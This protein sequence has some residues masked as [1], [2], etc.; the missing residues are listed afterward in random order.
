MNETLNEFEAAADL[1]KT[2]GHHT[3]LLK[4]CVG[5]GRS[6]VR[7]GASDEHIAAA[8]H[9]ASEAALSCRA[10]LDQITAALGNSNR[11]A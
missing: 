10:T 7:A 2:L 1:V 6:L 8:R 5:S 11:A 9:A 3:Q 4:I